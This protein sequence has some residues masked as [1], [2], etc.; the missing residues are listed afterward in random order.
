MGADTYRGTSAAGGDPDASGLVNETRYTGDGY[1]ST[2]GYTERGYAEPHD[3]K[4]LGQLFGELTTDLSDLVRGEV[5]LARAEMTDK[6]KE[7]AKGGAMAGA[8]ALVAYAGLVV[9]LI[10]LALVLAEFMEL[11]IATLIVAALTLAVGAILLVVGRNKF[12]NTELT[13][14]KTVESIKEDVQWAKE[15]VQ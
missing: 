5:M 12:K 9:L 7:V 8:G 15:Q 10:A 2:A 14:E 13:P 3:D 6:A 4:T 11:W 1:T